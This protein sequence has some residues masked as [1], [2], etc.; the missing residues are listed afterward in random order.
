MTTSLTYISGDPPEILQRFLR[1]PL[2][3]DKTTNSGSIQLIFTSNSSSILAVHFFFLVMSLPPIFSGRGLSDWISLLFFIY[4][5]FWN[6]Q[7]IKSSTKQKPNYDANPILTLQFRW[8]ISN[9]F[10]S[11]TKWLCHYRLHHLKFILIIRI[12]AISRLFIVFQHQ[13]HFTDSISGFWRVL[14]LGRCSEQVQSP[15]LNVNP[16]D[17]SCSG[18]LRIL[19]GSED[20]STGQFRPS[21][22]WKSSSSQSKL[23]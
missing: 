14:R 18:M 3:V 8:I 11:V 2:T 19:Q 12:P 10:H 9:S 21:G 20:A 4:L 5:F 22:Q 7:Q 23:R 13:M 1:D 6:N 15:N 17:W 16:P